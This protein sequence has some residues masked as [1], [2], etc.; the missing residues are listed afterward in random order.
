MRS[1]RP[2]TSTAAITII[3]LQILLRLIGRKGRRRKRRGALLR[4]LMMILMRKWSDCHAL[5]YI[6]LNNKK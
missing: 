1:G 2:R 5:L 4:E 3:K 6:Q